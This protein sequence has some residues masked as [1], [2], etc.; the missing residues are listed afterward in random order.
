MDFGALKTIGSFADSGLSVI[1]GIAGLASAGD[2]GRE[3]K[4]LLAFRADANRKKVQESFKSNYAKQMSKYAND[5]SD[6]SIQR[7]QAENSIL[8]QATQNVGAVDIQGSSFRT[9]AEATL[10]NEFESEMNKLIDNHMNANLSLATKSIEME[11]DIDLAQKQGNLRIDQETAS[12]KTQALGQ[13]VSGVTGSI[14]KI[15]N[16]KAEKESKNNTLESIENFDSE[17]QTPDYSD[18]Y[19][20]SQVKSWLD[21]TKNKNQSIDPIAYMLRKGGK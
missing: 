8:S 9:T 13:I 11:K 1:S 3:K 20:T 12:A 6:I 17:L 7:T 2:I 19:F 18:K 21:L 10:N 16:M 14:G 5:L 4:K 15:L